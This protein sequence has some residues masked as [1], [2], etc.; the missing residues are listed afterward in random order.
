MGVRNGSS[1]RYQQYWIEIRTCARNL[2]VTFCSR[3]L[4][5][6]FI[7]RPL[8]VSHTH[9]HTHTHV[10]KHTHTHTQTN[11]HTHTHTHTNKQTNT[12]N[13]Q[14]KLCIRVIINNIHCAEAHPR[15]HI[16][17][18]QKQST[19]PCLLC[20]PNTADLTAPVRSPA[21]RASPRVHHQH[22]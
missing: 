14:T 22:G 15:L 20:L 3:V 11:T 7:I 6:L 16:S 8:P 13:T 18:C 9:T 1:D 19:M 21:H 5:R 12:A 17:V 4:V 10:H 2:V